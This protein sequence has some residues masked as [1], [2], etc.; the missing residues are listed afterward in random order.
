MKKVEFQEA[1]CQLASNATMVILGTKNCFKATPEL[2]ELDIAKCVLQSFYKAWYTEDHDMEVMGSA[3]EA[4]APEMAGINRERFIN[5]QIL[6]AINMEIPSAYDE[7]VHCPVMFE[8]ND[9]TKPTYIQITRG[10]P[11]K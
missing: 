5:V 4:K 2:S 3:F 6:S 11:T 8:N 10:L 9:Y 1:M 7:D